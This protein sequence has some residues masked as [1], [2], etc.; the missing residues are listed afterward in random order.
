MSDFLARDDSESNGHCS[1]PSL[2]QMSTILMVASSNGAGAVPP[3]VFLVAALNLLARS[4]AAYLS[5]FHFVET[6]FARTVLS[7][8]FFS[9]QYFL[10]KY[11]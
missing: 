4:F 11:I 10:K 6:C 1:S 7:G 8:I 9:S 3:P 2:E 5:F